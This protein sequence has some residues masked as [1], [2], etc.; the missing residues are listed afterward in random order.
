MYVR[1]YYD[2]H[3][4]LHDI[5]AGLLMDRQ[6]LN[7]R[8]SKL[9]V[10]LSSISAEFNAPPLF[11]LDDD[12][13]DDDDDDLRVDF[14][15]LLPARCIMRTPKDSKMLCPMHAARHHHNSAA[16]ERAY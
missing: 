12:D 1:T 15:I 10:C 13:D 8:S 3:T 16:T 11:P 5:V 7:L 4:P 6:S 14:I 2:V 9:F